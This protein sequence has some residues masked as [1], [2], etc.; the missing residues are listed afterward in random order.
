MLKVCG[1]GEKVGI[2]V[3]PECCS[4]RDGYRNRRHCSGRTPRKEHLLLG[5]NA[6]PRYAEERGRREKKCTRVR[7]TRCE[8][9]GGPAWSEGYHFHRMKVK[10]DS[11]G[12]V[13]RVSWRRH[14]G[15][16][17]GCH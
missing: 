15:H 12:A 7:Q 11:A 6:T 17:F 1:L 10:L 9:R 8:Q 3:A 13:R 16:A 14:R 2:G 4:V 5:T